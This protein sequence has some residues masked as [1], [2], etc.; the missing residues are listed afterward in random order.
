MKYINK[1]IILVLTLMISI[2]VS[3]LVFAATVKVDLGTADAFAVL[4][5]TEV[6][7]VPTSVITGNVGLS[8]AAGSNYDSG[9]TT[10][11][12]TGNI[13][14]VDGTGPLGAINNPGLLTIAKSSLTTA[15]L[16][17]AGR[18]PTTT[19][20]TT[21]NQ[22]GGQTLTTGVYSF[23]H[24]DTANLTA[25]SPLT[26]D[27]QNNPDAV[28]ILQATSDLV[29]ASGS[30]VQLINGAQSCNVFWQVTSSATLGSGSTF[31]GTIM[32]LTSITVTS[33]ANIQGRALARN[34]AVT[35]DADTITR[36]VCSTRTRLVDTSGNITNKTKS[37]ISS[38]IIVLAGMS[39]IYFFSRM[40]KRRTIN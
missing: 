31:K 38:I 11:Q 33:G 29:T 9:V 23:G 8:P 15:Y 10:A 19:F 20:A 26:L 22:L 37:T 14:A 25:A 30:V 18:T 24:A 4:A 5:G 36:P 16:D 34:G 3:S 32:A 40:I 12:I 35:L 7:N 13:Y 6:T 27:A 39:S 1:I 17:A 2:G 28:F 21:D